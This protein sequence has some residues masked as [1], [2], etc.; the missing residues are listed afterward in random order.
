MLKNKQ[1]K[2]N[3]VSGTVSV[4]AH[5]VTFWYDIGGYP[6]TAEL[7]EA[8]TQKAEQRAKTCIIDGYVSGELNCYYVFDSD[9]DA[10]IR[11]MWEIE[12]AA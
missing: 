1:R 8:L 4:C 5:R 9:H 10:E 2:R 7:D 6:L 3:V 12:R 11:G